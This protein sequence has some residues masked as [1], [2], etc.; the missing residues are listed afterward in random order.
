M[1]L[2]GAEAVDSG[3]EVDALRAGGHVADDHFGCRHVG[4]LAQ[5]VVL[6][7]P[8]VLPVVEIGLDA[9]LDLPLEHEVLGP[10]VEGR[11]AGEIPVDEDSELHEWG[12]SRYANVCP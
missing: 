3:P 10:A 4:V 1:L 5:A 9:V 12:S 11:R 7:V 6:A 2:A 8:G